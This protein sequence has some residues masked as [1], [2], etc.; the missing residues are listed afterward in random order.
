MGR[1]G[2][3]GL[4]GGQLSAFCLAGSQPFP[5]APPL[6]EEEQEKLMTGVC[7]AFVL[8][9]DRTGHCSASDLNVSP[10]DGSW[11]TLLRQ[12]P[13]L[14]IAV[15]ERG[16]CREP[17]AEGE[18]VHRKRGSAVPLVFK[19][20]APSALRQQ[21]KS[22]PRGSAGNRQAGSLNWQGPQRTGPC[23]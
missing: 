13:G 12:T 10:W 9:N 19:R 7:I 16:P 6:E 8:W 23:S 2:E 3:D 4:T 1:L 18:R 20:L 22:L 17:L 15:A 11:P 5:P 14:I 21:E